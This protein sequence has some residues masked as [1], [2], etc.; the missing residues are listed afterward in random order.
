MRQL[1]GLALGIVVTV[2]SL[3]I[4]AAITQ[5]TFATVNA[6]APSST[7]TTINTATGTSLTTFANF[8]PVI[9]IAGVGGLALV[10]LIS[11]LSRPQM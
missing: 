8:L 6:S 4:G 9:V 10:F 3:M 2:V 11:Y 5:T 7:L 1:F